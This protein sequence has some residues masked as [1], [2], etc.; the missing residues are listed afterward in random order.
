MTLKSRLRMIFATIIVLLVIPTMVHSV[1]SADPTSRL[2]TVGGDFLV[3]TQLAQPLEI[4]LFDEDPGGGGGGVTIPGS[5]LEN[6]LSG[7]G[8]NDQAPLVA[9]NNDYDNYLVVWQIQESNLVDLYGRYLDASGDPWADPFIIAEDLTWP[10]GMEL[11]YGGGSYLLLWRDGEDRYQGN[12]YMAAIWGNRTIFPVRSGPTLVQSPILDDFNVIYDSTRDHF[13]VMWLDDRNPDLYQVLRGEIY[14]RKVSNAGE[15]LEEE[16]NLL[17]LHANPGAVLQEKILH[18]PSASGTLTIAYSPGSDHFLIVFSNY[19]CPGDACTKGEDVRA[20][21]LSAADMIQVRQQF[22]IT[23]EV[24]GAQW[25]SRVL[26]QPRTDEFFIFWSDRRF[27]ASYPNIYGSRLAGDGSDDLS[28]TDYPLV[29]SLGDLEAVRG[30]VIEGEGNDPAYALVW[31]EQDFAGSPKQ[32]YI[33][34][35]DQDAV[36]V[37]QGLVPSFLPDRTRVEPAVAVG[38]G[39]YPGALMVWKDY[40]PYRESDIHGRLIPVDTYLGV[41][42]ISP[43]NFDMVFSVRPTFTWVDVP[44]AASFVLRIYHYSSTNPTNPYHDIE[45]DLEDTW[46]PEEPYWQSYKLTDTQLLEIGP[47]L[48]ESGQFWKIEALDIAGNSLGTSMIGQFQVPPLGVEPDRP[49]WSDYDSSIYYWSEVYDLPPN[50]YKAVLASESGNMRVWFDLDPT[51]G[52][53]YEGKHDEATCH[54]NGSEGV[55]YCW[56][57]YFIPFL[58]GLE[59]NEETGPYRPPEIW[60]GDNSFLYRNPTLAQM[61]GTSTY[62]YLTNWLAMARYTGCTGYQHP[63]SSS[64][65]YNCLTNWYGDRYKK[66]EFQVMAGYGLSGINYWTNLRAL[67]PADTEKPLPYQ[68]PADV[69]YV[70]EDLYNSDLNIRIGTRVLS[71]KRCWWQNASGIRIPYLDPESP[72][73]IYLSAADYRYEDFIKWRQVLAAYAGYSFHYPLWYGGRL[74]VT[75]VEWRFFGEDSLGNPYFGTYPVDVSGFADLGIEVDVQIEDSPQQYSIDKVYGATWRDDVWDEDYKLCPYPGY[76]QASENTLKYATTIGSSGLFSLY[77]V[78]NQDLLLHGSE[79]D[80]EGDG[81][82]EWV[83]LTWEGDP[84]VHAIHQAVI[85]VFS[86]PEGINL[87]WESPPLLDVPPLGFGMVDEI[88]QW[89]REVFLAEFPVSLHSSQTFIVGWNN[90]VF[91]LLEFYDPFV[92]SSDRLV[93]TGGGVFFLPDGS[94]SVL[95]R[96]QDP[97]EEVDINILYGSW[98]RYLPLVTHTI[99]MTENDTTPPTTRAEFSTPPNPDGWNSYGWVEIIAEDDQGVEYLECQKTGTLS[100][101]LQRR[102]LP[103]FSITMVEGRWDIHCQ[104]TDFFGNSGLGVQFSLQVDQTPPQSELLLNGDWDDQA[105]AYRGSVEVVAFSDDPPL[106]DGTEGSGV[107]EIQHSLD[108]GVT[109]QTFPDLLFLEDE[110]SYDLWVRGVDK[111]ENLEE[112]LQESFQILPTVIAIAPI[113]DQEQAEGAELTVA[114]TFQDPTPDVFHVGFFDWGDGSLL[115]VVEITPLPEGGWEVTGRH[116]YQDNGPYQ[117]VLEVINTQGFTS[118]EY[119]MV[120]VYNLPPVVEAG[121]DVTAGPGELITFNGSFTDPGGEDTHI[122]Y[123]RFGDGTTA[124]DTLTPTH[125]YPEVGVYEVIL[126]VD[127]D[128]GD[129]HSDLLLVTIINQPPEVTLD[130][131]GVINEGDTFTRVGSFSDVGSESWTGEVDYGLGAGYQPLTLKS[132]Q[133]FAL[134]QLYPEDGFFTINVRITDEENAVGDASLALTVHNLPPEVTLSGDTS[135]VEGETFT[136]S[137]SFT[138]PGAD[139]WTA[140]VDYGEGAGPEALPLTGMTFNLEQLYPEDGLFTVTVC[141]L[142]DDGG[143]GCATLDLTVANGAPTVDAGPDQTA[144]AGE[145]VNFAGSFTDPGVE[146]THTFQWEFGD[147]AA[148][149][150]LAATHSYQ[151]PG[152]YTATLTVTDDEGGIGSDSLVVTVEEPTSGETIVLNDSRSDNCLSLDLESGDFFWYAEDGE[153]YSGTAD[154]VQ[155]GKIIL[156]RTSGWETPYLRGLLITQNGMGVARLRVGRWFRGPWYFILDRDTTEPGVCQ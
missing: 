13:W 10:V 49:Y 114:T 97:A 83:T 107:A 51:R 149:I 109:W 94:I 123:W 27:S 59:R 126:Q 12:L 132:D 118:R 60:P 127:D 36:P 54:P 110:G 33:Q 24:D 5:L 56:G 45:L 23:D 44:E 81:E 104:A 1:L 41:R 95:N 93:S 147:G 78:P 151:V 18:A 75:R 76:D 70:P 11:T 80:F 64:D 117:A 141:V 133:T 50:L 92:G 156:F 100:E 120:N 68:P 40:Q 69:S 61:M 32:S 138:D 28:P 150:T 85:R 91:S 128:D 39:S 46:D 29:E 35:L 65:F 142:D 6:D 37:G 140:T 106:S 84:A 115:D 96:G 137:G 67:Y 89:D 124:Y 103:G 17:P 26:Y 7:T 130:G 153:I 21:R 31:T 57:D 8:I 19:N 125:S 98:P 25:Q 66:A 30:A 79:V 34:Y 148:A 42:L 119:F 131:D 129:N 139:T 71:D 102:Y 74:Q 47:S 152:T 146:D 73:H 105:G 121:E 48:H 108:Q 22:P 154:L 63:S 14:G 53:L 101:E 135:L 62:A 2:K 143:E 86:D 72:D 99:D 16:I 134:E 38:N 116:T 52:Y 43:R 111:A 87:L 3:P 15:F 136:G 82:P 122:I 90:G 112:P 9:Y 155:R 77:A 144:T 145:M 20:L 58:I 88:Q 55:N 113:L 4:G